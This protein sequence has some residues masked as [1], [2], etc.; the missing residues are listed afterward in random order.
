MGPLE[1]V[2]EKERGWL[3]RPRRG[4]GEQELDAVIAEW[5]RA[6]PPLAGPLIL[7]SSAL[8][9]LPVAGPLR[10]GPAAAA[11]GR[12]W[13]ASAGG[14]PRLSPASLTRGETERVWP[15]QGQRQGLT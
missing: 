14:P 15:A 12:C 8:K 1:V 3:H 9:V 13:E 4:E 7:K 6:S 2:A 5:R 10:A 11:R